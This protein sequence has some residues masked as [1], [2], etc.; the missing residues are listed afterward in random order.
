MKKTSTSL[1]PAASEA[2]AAAT[3]VVKEAV[4]AAA[5]AAKDAVVRSNPYGFLPMIL[6]LAIPFAVGAAA[7]FLGPDEPT[8]KPNALVSLFSAPTLI[9]AGTGYALGAAVKADDNTRLAYAAVGLGTGWIVQHYII[10]PREMK[11]AAAAAAAQEVEEASQAAWYK[12]W[13][14]F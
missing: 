7:K 11:D 8:K 6:P 14:W 13:T 3:P 10:V 2:A 4:V 1:V 12:P 5:N 9:G